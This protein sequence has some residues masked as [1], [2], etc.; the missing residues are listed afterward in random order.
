MGLLLS[1]FNL[2]KAIMKIKYFI[3]E[4][5]NDLKKI[6]VRFRDG[7]R[8]DKVAWT[9]KHTTV[10]LWNPDKEEIRNI[11]Q[12]HISGIESKEQIN[13][14]LADLKI[15]LTAKY[16]EDFAKSLTIEKNWLKDT[17]KSFS[18]RIDKA[19]TS[20]DVYF[21]TA[22]IDNFLDDKKNLLHTKT[23]KPLSPAT[24]KT[25]KS[26]L[27]KIKSFENYEGTNFRFEDITY[28]KFY[29]PFLHYL[30]E[31]ENLNENTSGKYITVLKTF[32]SLIDAD[33]RHLPIALDFQKKNK[34]TSVSED[35]SA[36]YLN[37]AEINKIFNLD[38]SHNPR[39][40]NVRDTF[41]IGLWT[42]LRISDFKRLDIT[43]IKDDIITITTQKTNK[44]VGIGM[45]P[46][47]K[48]TLDKRNG[49]FPKTI[50]DQK[51]N[52]YVKEVVQLAE[53]NN[54]VEGSKLMSVKVNGEDRQRKVKGVYEKWELIS[55][56]TC[57]R[58][59]ATNMYTAKALPLIV[60]MSLTGH[61]TETQ[62]ID[63]VKVTPEENAKLMNDYY[64]GKLSKKN[65][66]APLKVV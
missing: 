16:N 34:F 53:I 63:Y 12:S 60:L 22:W 13:N 66:V 19:E 1:L 43:N 9:E 42:G 55:S 64:N 4:T 33:E 14:Y 57:R 47:L 27:A 28:Q 20:S 11:S 17:I 48:A 2:S 44:K 51:F 25:Y 50:S 10:K 15:F 56:H 46:Q 65:L 26:T 6:F 54:L 35:A 18:N 21:L 23:K 32:L 36:V 38:L 37:E 52:E 40:N 62:F 39:L 58:S 45:H 3:K 29:K 30:R 41:I 49:E 59:F 5:D 24:V 7:R 61:K 31:V 8:F